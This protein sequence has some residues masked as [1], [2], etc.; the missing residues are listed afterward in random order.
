MIYEHVCRNVD[1]R[2]KPFVLRALAAYANSY[3]SYRDGEG[4]H[5]V[6]TT[7]GLPSGVKPT[8][9]IGNL[10]NAVIMHMAL[11]IVKIVL[12]SS[13]DAAIWVR[14][15]DAKILSLSVVVLALFRIVLAALN[16]IG[17]NSKFG[18]SPGHVEFLR[19][20]ILQ[21]QQRGW[22]CRTIPGMVQ[23]KPWNSEPWKPAGDTETLFG[24]V[25]AIER[26]SGKKIPVLTRMVT[27][28]FSRIARMDSRWLSVPVRAGGFG[29][30]KD[31]GWRASEVLPTLTRPQLSV[32]V[33]KPYP[34]PDWLVGTDR[35]K[36]SQSVVSSLIVADDVPGTGKL[37]RQNY[38]NSMKSVKPHWHKILIPYI[39]QFPLILDLNSSVEK[40]P[41]PNLAS[42]KTNSTLLQFITEYNIAR[43]Y[44]KL[45]TLSKLLEYYF[46]QPYA[47]IKQWTR[48]GWHMTDAINLVL[49]NKPI[50]PRTS[51]HPLLNRFAKYYL[52]QN[53]RPQKWKTR[54][55][56]ATNLAL[57][58]DLVAGAVSTTKLFSYYLF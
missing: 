3:I 8:S 56:I 10:W 40:Q 14:G 27:K 30:L 22:S 2:V 33:S 54:D 5:I 47:L 13:V 43:M 53:Y 36:Y 51:Y 49:G 31:R 1:N 17:S 35:M 7:G 6:K 26:R 58:S 29:L 19:N 23:R 37:M 28:R 42:S 45:P 34:V 57:T 18:I 46:P 24:R 11:E 25:A 32:S 9:I 16:A 50:E 48:R 55:R 39:Q 52:W 41:P 20:N 4:D 21:N 38:N 15:D 44:Q 12:G